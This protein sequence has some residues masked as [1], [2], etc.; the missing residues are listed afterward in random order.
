LIA[1]S[2]VIRASGGRAASTVGGVAAGAR[3]AT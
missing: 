3:L 2:G 1:C